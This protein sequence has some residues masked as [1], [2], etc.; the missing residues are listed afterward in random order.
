[1]DSTGNKRVIRFDGH[2]M[3][4]K[5]H[6]SLDKSLKNQF[7]NHIFESTKAKEHDVA[8]AAG[9]EKL[10]AHKVILAAASPFL[11]EVF[12]LDNLDPQCIFVS[13]LDFKDL[14]AFKTLIYEGKVEISLAQMSGLQKVAM[15]LKV[16][17]PQLLSQDESS[18]FYCTSSSD[19]KGFN[20]QETLSPIASSST[21]ADMSVD[22][23]P[24]ISM[25]SFDFLK[26]ESVTTYPAENI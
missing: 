1:M 7:A 18:S 26:E 20:N 15:A 11:K 6:K 21:L 25:V 10:G 16:N 12:S 9:D 5:I 3:K 14:E 2:A 17:I 19:F 4:E 22:S 23:L 8:L 13:D 24:N